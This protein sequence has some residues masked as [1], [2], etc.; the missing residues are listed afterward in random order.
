MRLIRARLCIEKMT[1]TLISRKRIVCRDR[2]RAMKFTR[3]HERLGKCPEI[4]GQ[5]IFRSK[6]VFEQLTITK[7]KGGTR[8]TS[9]FFR[10]VVVCVIFFHFC[11]LIYALADPLCKA[12][13]SQHSGQLNNG[14]ISMPSDANKSED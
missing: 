4:R 7:G 8:M 3:A 1:C 10:R 5:H 14:L 11:L 2:S 9:V 6:P 13:C 12:R